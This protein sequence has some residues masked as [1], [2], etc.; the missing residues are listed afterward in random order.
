[1]SLFDDEAVDSRVGKAKLSRGFCFTINNPDEQAEGACYALECSPHFVYCVVG[2][3]VGESGTLH[4]QGYVYFSTFK[5]FRQVQ[6]MFP[7]G[8]HVENS[9]GDSLSNFKYCSKDGDYFEAG[10]RPKTQKEKG[11]MEKERYALAFSSAKEGKLLEIEPELLVRHYTTWKNIQKDYGCKPL[12]CDDVTGVWI[13]GAA[14]A[15]KSR[16][17]REQFSGAYFKN[18]NKWWDGYQYEDNVI[19]DDFAP[20]HHVLGYHL[21]I[22]ADRYSFTAEV[23]G[24]ALQI[25]PKRIIIT[26]QYSIRQCFGDDETT[27]AAIDRRFK[28]I[29]VVSYDT[30]AALF[31]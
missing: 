22:W 5:S 9:K 18:A 16:I 8:I 13:H 6:E 11:V 27:I 2:K 24:G 10:V 15:G 23:K 17:A 26:S 29:H 21:K 14:G 1:M 12:D 28:S 31:V 25:R 19:L 20:V 30:A 3:E 4:L 7:C